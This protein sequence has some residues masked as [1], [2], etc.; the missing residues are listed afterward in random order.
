MI[1]SLPAQPHASEET[2]AKTT[3]KSVE[4]VPAKPR[5]EEPRSYFAMMLLAVLA[6]PTG[7]ARAYRGEKSG[8]TRFWVY[9]GSNVI[10]VIPILGQI[11]GGLS[12]LVLTIIGAV[13]VFKLRKSTT[14]AFD[15]PLVITEKDK[16][17]ANGFYIYF[18]VT[19][20]IIAL[21]VLFVTSLFGWAIQQYI[22]NGG[23][24]GSFPGENSNT[25]QQ[26]AEPDSF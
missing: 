10:M 5:K 19:L 23:V 8:W 15:H 22:N 6:L 13:D 14:D 24:G 9:I 25:L 18:I 16:Q 3:K 2:A 20:V 21:V 26:Y 1:M 17:W 11:I 4:V 12:L 7:L